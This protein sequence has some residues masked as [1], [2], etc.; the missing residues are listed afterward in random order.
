MKE[1]VPLLLVVSSSQDK[2]WNHRS[3][4]RSRVHIKV[5]SGSGSMK[6][7]TWLG[8]RGK[9]KTNEELEDRRDVS[10]HSQLTHLI[11]SITL[12]KEDGYCT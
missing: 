3:R 6:S 7:D 12:V 10:A 11:W 5:L 4:K 1:A 9:E 8:H 2:V